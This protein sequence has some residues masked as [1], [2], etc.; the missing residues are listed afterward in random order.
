MYFR[1]MAPRF[2]LRVFLYLVCNSIV[3]LPVVYGQE[4][5]K[6][7]TE[8]A[9]EKNIVEI[10]RKKKVK[11]PASLYILCKNKQFARTVNVIWDAKL[12]HC[13]TQY[14]KFGRS[15]VV[16]SGKNKNTCVQ[17]LNNIRHNLEKAG[18]F[19]KAI[20]HAKV[21]ISDE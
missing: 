12:Q 14:T 19:C 20:D 5:V 17:F 21:V 1:S 15:K 6:K 16:G 18:W 7:E 13:E 11:Y 10:N 4:E 3:F 9:A 2:I 8:V